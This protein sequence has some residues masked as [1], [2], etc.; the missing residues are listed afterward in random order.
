MSIFDGFPRSNAYQINLDWLLKS[1]RELETYVKNYTAINNV[2]YAGIWDITKQYPKWALVS[3][4]DST[5][6]SLQP[7]PVGVPL[8][9][10]EYWVK[11][12]DLDQR[13]TGIL[14]D[15]A[16][17]FEESE[18]AQNE[19][20]TLRA[21]L[22]AEKKHNSFTRKITAPRK[23]A[24][25]HDN[26]S[27]RAMF[28]ATDDGDYF[29]RI[30]GQF[31]GVVDARDA[32]LF[33]EPETKTLFMCCTNYGEGAFKLYYTKNLVE[34]NIYW[35]PKPAGDTG[36]YWA[37]SLAPADNKTITYYVTHGTSLDSEKS[38]YRGT[39]SI[40]ANGTPT[41]ASTPAYIFGP[42]FID[43][44]VVT[45]SEQ[46]MLAV[47]NE[48]TKC[49]EYWTTDPPYAKIKDAPTMAGIEAATAT[50]FNG[51]D[52]LYADYYFNT[53]EPLHEIQNI[54]RYAVINE[55]YSPARKIVFSDALNDSIQGR[56]HGSIIDFPVDMLDSFYENYT[57]DKGST[58][59]NN[60][61]GTRYVILNTLNPESG[62]TI[63][64]NYVYILQ[65]TG[66]ITI[67]NPN[68][69]YG[70][71][72]YPILIQTDAI[73]VTFKESDGDYKF[74]LNG[75]AGKMIIMKQGQD[76]VFAPCG[77]TPSK[78]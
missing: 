20:E 7:V 21:E 39:I 6:M 76:T 49:L 44:E 37:P 30:S 26:D 38:I 55:R 71:S 74:D 18:N 28:Y 70:L 19:I 10:G 22:A 3:F 57:Y 8:E 63:I 61:Y 64:P 50:S 60:A 45:I 53:N 24:V 73:T 33:Y 62:F 68:N 54:V 16:K 17:L 40:D 42:N 27:A 59:S 13:I 35:I 5:Y 75:Q 43:P 41:G 52:Y 25:F 77:I 78:K 14:Q 4:K 48:N 29:G 66:E 65:G 56:R 47:K 12:A 36:V 23:L 69:P 9:N 15:I 32:S 11:L 46:T 58:I 51:R 67:P 72:E 2:A 31:R 34:W 1:M